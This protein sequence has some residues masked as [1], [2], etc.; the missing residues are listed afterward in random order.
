MGGS[1]SED[2][3]HSLATAWMI[4]ISRRH[5]VSSVSLISIYPGSVATAEAA[6]QQLYAVTLA[7][8]PKET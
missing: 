8:T 2:Y 6:R 5:G 1:K 4:A 3:A 7:K